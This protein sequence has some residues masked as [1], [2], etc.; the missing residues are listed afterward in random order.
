MDKGITIEDE[1]KCINCKGQ[2]FQFV[3]QGRDRMHDISGEFSIL[4]CSNCGLFTLRPRLSPEEISAYYPDDYFSFVKAI[5]DESK[6]IQYIDRLL[7][8]ERRVRK[9]LKYSQGPGRILDVGCATGILL[10]GMQLRGWDCYGVEPDLKAVE[11]ARTRFNLNVFH[12][13]IRDADFPRDFFDVVT[14]MDVLEHIHDT[15]NTLIEVHRILKPKGII[16]GIVPNAGAWERFFF[17]PCWGGWDVPRHY[18][19][20]TSVTI[21]QLLETHGFTDVKIFSF[22]GRHGAFMISLKFWLDEWRGPRWLKFIAYGF[23][24][25][26]PVRMLMLPGFYISES[27]NKSSYLSFSARK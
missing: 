6:I 16:L 18:H 10:C 8:R 23:F 27:L 11:Y 24:G 14:L 7:A 3:Y 9:I 13:T 12:G 25:S 20:F 4:E 2:S 19:V 5:E 22:T 1:I 21:H 17:G 26:L 15:E